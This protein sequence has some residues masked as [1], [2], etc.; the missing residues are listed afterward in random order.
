MI[1]W[2][3]SLLMYRTINNNTENRHALGFVQANSKDEAIGKVLRIGKKVYPSIEGWR[4]HHIVVA[5]VNTSPVI[6]PE[7]ATREEEP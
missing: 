7:T 2:A 1:K 4:D 5:D 6:E 3:Y